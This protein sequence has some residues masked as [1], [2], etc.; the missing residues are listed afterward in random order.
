MVVLTVIQ[1]DTTPTGSVLCTEIL[2]SVYAT[3]LLSTVCNQELQLV[4]ACDNAFTLIWPHDTEQFGGG[5]VRPLEV[6]D[7]VEDPANAVVRE[8]NTL[9]PAQE[10]VDPPR[11]QLRAQTLQGHLLHVL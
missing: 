8:G 4:C 1:R 2:S 3:L 6:A 11:G 9:H 10:Q 5:H 7:G